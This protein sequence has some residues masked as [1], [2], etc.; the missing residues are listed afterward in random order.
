M[1]ARLLL[2]KRLRWKERDVVVLNESATCLHSKL[3]ASQHRGFEQFLISWHLIV[4][5]IAET[6][7][8]F[9]SLTTSIID[10]STVWLCQHNA[11]VPLVLF[12]ECP[13]RAVQWLKNAHQQSYFWQVVH[14]RLYV[15]EEGIVWTEAEVSDGD[16]HDVEKLVLTDDDVKESYLFDCLLDQDNFLRLEKPLVLLELICKVP[17]QQ[18]IREEV[19]DYDK[20]ADCKETSDFS[21]TE[22]HRFASLFEH[23]L[24]HEVK[25][26]EDCLGH[27][28]DPQ[29]NL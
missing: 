5:A 20:H 27:Y 1:A 26:N 16:L 17:L 21:D 8:G 24:A 13:H 29:T 4:C 6:A 2:M 3:C 12:L 19:P 7:T 10:A 9:V 22:Q 14:K 11:F 15:N 25:G 23:P 18:H 28:H